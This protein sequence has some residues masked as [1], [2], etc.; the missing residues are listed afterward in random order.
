MLWWS[1]PR[2]CGLQAE[3]ACRL[4]YEAFGLSSVFE[5]ILQG[6]WLLHWHWLKVLAWKILA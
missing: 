4:A 6:M 5:L 3:M 1:K 2:L